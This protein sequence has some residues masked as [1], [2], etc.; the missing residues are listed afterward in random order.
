MDDVEQRRDH[1]VGAADLGGLVDQREAG[2]GHPGVDVGRGLHEQQH[3]PE[4]GR[5]PEA[6]VQVDPVGELA[7]AVRRVAERARRGATQARRQRPPDRQVRRLGNAQGGG[8]PLPHDLRLSTPEMEEPRVVV[9]VRERVRMVDLGRE[10]DGAIGP[11]DR[12]I[13]VAAEPQEEARRRQ[14]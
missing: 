13:G 4:D 11:L 8:R 3:R 7:D 1:R 6:V 12:A 10:G 5:R 9:G 2:A 14:A